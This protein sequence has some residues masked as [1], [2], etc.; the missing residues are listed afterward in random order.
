MSDFTYIKPVKSNSAI[1]C[2]PDLSPPVDARIFQ[3]KVRAFLPGRSQGPISGTFS[4]DDRKIRA[5]YTAGE[6]V[7]D[8]VLDN[9]TVQLGSVRHDDGPTSAP[10]ALVTVPNP[11]SELVLSSAQVEM[12]P[13]ANYIVHDRGDP[14]SIA[15]AFLEGFHRGELAT[16]VDRLAYRL[17]E[18]A[19]GS[20]HIATLD[21]V[22]VLDPSTLEASGSAKWTAGLR[23]YNEPRPTDYMKH[24]TPAVGQEYYERINKNFKVN[25]LHMRLR[26]VVNPR[27]ALAAVRLL[28]KVDNDLGL[29]LDA[30]VIL[31]VM[32]DRMV[33]YTR[34][35]AGGTLPQTRADG[36]V[37]RNNNYTR[38][39][40]TTQAGVF[41]FVRTPAG[42]PTPHT[43][44]PSTVAGRTVSFGR[45]RWERVCTISPLSGDLLTAASELPHV[46]WS[47]VFA[48]PAVSAFVANNVERMLAVTNDRRIGVGGR[49]PGWKRP[50]PAAPAAPAADERGGYVP[51]DAPYRDF[52]ELLR[53]FNLPT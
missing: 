30:E 38:A 35:D 31:L 28:M 33:R 47:L 37:I 40:V 36:I 17:V 21:R 11:K 43:A 49:P 39:Y 52:D 19:F 34:D 27:H 10:S 13:F 9:M 18:R 29:D 4:R 15:N 25:A 50:R 1:L 20:D 12:R 51:E 5:T 41:A 48:H 6:T 3:E 24:T 26:P 2:D 23:H 53:A 44:L 22:E 46:A 32:R 7:G 16:L 45:R 14:M 8:C 42:I